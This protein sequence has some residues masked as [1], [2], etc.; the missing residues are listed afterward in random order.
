MPNNEHT[1]TERTITLTPNYEHLFRTMI[2]S[3]QEQGDAHRMFL[4]R[5]DRA[6]LLREV[7]RW[8]APL[9]IATNSAATV[10]AIEELRGVM[11]DMLT[12]LD[13]EAQRVERVTWE[14]EDALEMSEDRR[15]GLL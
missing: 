2:K 3:A 9:T 1:E 5:A 14:A 13:Q 15:K 8:F 12:A 4:G 10:P 11:T 6:E 7:Q